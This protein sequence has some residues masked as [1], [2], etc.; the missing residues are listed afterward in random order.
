ML[1]MCGPPKQET[2]KQEAQV[3]AV[4]AH[5]TSGS[6]TFL[7]QGW[8]E[9]QR[10]QFYTTSQGSQMMPLDWFLSL[11]RA[12]SEQLFTNDGLDRYGYLPNAKS[13]QNPWG[14]PVGFVQDPADPAPGQPPVG[15][16]W[17]GMTCSACHTNRIEYSDKTMQIDGAPTDADL[18][19]FVADLSLSL[20]ATLDNDAKFTRF[21]DRV[22]AKDD[23]SR[24]DLRNEVTRFSAYF[25]TFVNASTSPHAWGPSRTDA[26]GLIFNRVSAIDLS[27]NAKWAWLRPLEKNNALP[28]APVSYPY[29]YNVS[30]L[31]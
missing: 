26:F 15:G 16:R 22:G 9:A 4:P 25:A 18:Y 29:L 7:D 8:I 17:V 2:T 5:H 19:K 12:D 10:Q 24:R 6:V 14:L 1:V 21:A 23:K 30:R 13:D 28:N 11:E 3:A 27:D 31:D 20:K